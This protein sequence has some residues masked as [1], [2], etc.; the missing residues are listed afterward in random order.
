M[1][2]VARRPTGHII[3]EGR[4]ENKK[5]RI[6]YTVLKLMHLVFLLAYDKSIKTLM[7]GCLRLL[8]T[9]HLLICQRVAKI[10]LKAE[11]LQKN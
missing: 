4:Q 6:K 9:S 1:G 10:N 5:R 3:I 7:R 11:K 8:T 2:C